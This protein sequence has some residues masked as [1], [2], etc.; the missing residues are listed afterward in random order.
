MAP[1]KYYVAWNYRETEG[2]EAVKDERTKEDEEKIKEFDNDLEK[3]ERYPKILEYGA[4][5]QFVPVILVE[6]L[7][8]DKTLDVPLEENKAKQGEETIPPLTEKEVPSEKETGP[9]TQ[10]LPI[11]KGKGPFAGNVTILPPEKPIGGPSIAVHTFDNPPTNECPVLEEFAAN[12]TQAD[13]LKLGLCKLS[14]DQLPLWEA[15]CEVLSKMSSPEN[16][17]SFPRDVASIFTRGPGEELAIPEVS[18][19]YFGIDLEEDEDETAKED[20]TGNS[21]AKDQDPPVV[22]DTRGVEERNPPVKETSENQPGNDSHSQSAKQIQTRA[23]RFIAAIKIL[24]RRTKEAEFYSRQSAILQN[25]LVDREIPL[26]ILEDLD[27]NEEA[28]EKTAAEEILLRLNEQDWEIVDLKDKLNQCINQLRVLGF[29]G[30]IKPSRF[31]PKG[32]D[33]SI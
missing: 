32:K 7:E 8:A 14:T 33:L 18:D 5:Q 9:S 27:E 6:E 4:V 26:P 23:E 25:I 19:E 1:K 22:G 20:D 15:F 21:G 10:P 3:L 11:E 17:V 30:V 2:F 12:L 24:K 31:N 29:S 13:G 28:S 16:I